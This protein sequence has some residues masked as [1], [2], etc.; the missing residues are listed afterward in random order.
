MRVLVLCP[1]WIGD[2]VMA[3]PALRS[4]RRR[5]PEARIEGVGRP[6]VGD[7]LAGLPLLDGFIPWDPRSADETLRTPAVL[8][9]LRE[10]EIDVAL[11]LPHSFR[12]AWLAFRSGA[13]RRVGYRRDVRGWLLSDGLRSVRGNG[14]YVPTP[15]VETYLRLVYHLGC[16][17]ESWRLD[18]AT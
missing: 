9:R 13:R 8:R 3:T 15:A 18:L 7:V 10:E 14:R 11:V 4:L 2:T 6:P 17:E 12:A 5:F 1:N 16:P